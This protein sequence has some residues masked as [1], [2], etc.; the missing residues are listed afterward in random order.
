M[1]PDRSFLKALILVLLAI[2][3]HSTL[4]C[5]CVA[6]SVK[7]GINSSPR[8]FLASVTSAAP[9]NSG[10]WFEFGI[11]DVIVKKGG[12]IPFT[13][14]KTPRGSSACGKSLLVPG[15]YWFF[16]NE[17]GEFTS[18][19]ATTD[20]FDSSTLE[21]TRSVTAEIVEQKREEARRLREGQS[22]DDESGHP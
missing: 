21:L 1:A 6:D 8:V 9:S 17:S 18:C 4:A 12:S 3:T 14:V 5:S 20:A 15:K 11:T 13:S 7:D 10:D 22:K 2:A 19:S 16:T